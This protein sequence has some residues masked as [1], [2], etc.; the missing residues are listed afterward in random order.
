MTESIHSDE[1][2]QSTTDLENSQPTGRYLIVGLGNPGR[3]YRNNR[4][5]VGFRVVDL[6]AERHGLDLARLE[7]KALVGKGIVL[8]RQ[9]IVAKPQTYMN[10]SGRAVGQLLNYYDV[11][12]MNLMVVYDEIDLPLGT[13]RLRERGGSGGHNGMKSIIS[14]VGQDFPRLRLGVGRP[15]GRMEAAAYVLRDFKGDDKI[16]A[17]EMVSMAVDAIESYLQ[18]G[19]DKAMTRYNGSVTA[20]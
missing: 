20:S 8:T 4:H 14:H 2:L 18:D 6:L 15:P 3:K 1:K 19:I 11:P 12:L 16:T 7:L 13:L 9:V 10:E 17:E 5:N